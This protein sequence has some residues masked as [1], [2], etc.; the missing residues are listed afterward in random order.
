[1]FVT[2]R[3]K[4]VL[5]GLLRGCLLSIRRKL[6][7]LVRQGLYGM[8]D[9]PLA[10]FTALREALRPHLA[11]HGDRLNFLVLVPCCLSASEECQLG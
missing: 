10:Q 7:K 9:S 5:T 3:K 2:R 8:S 6:E 1:M 11:W 4:K